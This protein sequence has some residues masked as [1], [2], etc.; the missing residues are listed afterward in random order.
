M[1]NPDYVYLV[2]FDKLTKERDII[3]KNTEKL[4]RLKEA[5]KEKILSEVIPQCDKLKE[6]YDQLQ[7]L[8]VYKDNDYQNQQSTL[9]EVNKNL[10]KQFKIYDEEKTKAIISWIKES[11]AQL[12]K[13]LVLKFSNIKKDV[14]YVQGLESKL[15]EYKMK[16]FDKFKYISELEEQI[17]KYDKEKKTNKLELL[18]LRNQLRKLPYDIQVRIRKEAMKKCE[19][20]KISNNQ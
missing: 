7:H 12:N 20:E 11:K 18:Y 3:E 14:Q 4:R 9:I 19:N 6:E 13:N 2:Q 5:E 15:E 17:E 10:K 1:N 16:A 8:V